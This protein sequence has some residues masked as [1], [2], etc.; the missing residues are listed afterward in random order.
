MISLSEALALYPQSL[1]ALPV[2][3]CA[4]NDALGRV[5]AEPAVSAVDLP[6]FTQSAVDGYALN[7]VEA[8]QTLKLTGDIPAGSSAAHK[9]APG[10]AM[11]ILTGGVLPE[12]ADAVARQ[13]IVERAGPSIR[14]LKPVP[15]GADTRYRGEEL[16]QGEVIALAG[17]R[18]HSGLLAAL[19]MAGVE[20]V[21]A[22]RRPRLALLV[23]GDEIAAMGTA[24]KPGQVY[25]ANGPLMR[26]WFIEHGYPA[27][28]I[29]YVPDRPEAVE[30]ALAEALA[31][32]DFVISTGGVSVGDRDYL[33]DIAPKL[34]VEKIFWKVAQKPGK[35]L[36]FGVKDNKALLA[37]PGNPAAVLIGLAVHAACVLG[38][39]EGVAAP[40]PD[41]RMGIL[42]APVKADAHRDRLLRMS[43]DYDESGRV[44]LSALPKQ[45]SHML[46]NLGR[47]TALGWLEARATPYETGAVVRWLPLRM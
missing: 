26:S 21:R 14:L 19:A 18:L 39:M 27:P 30:Q 11:R 31:C 38:V 44:L 43:L 35:P 40:Q 9:L 10:A 46:S 33:P 22:H 1:R 2:E 41:W 12:G 45:D 6:L 25:D 28:E 23:T 47:A 15:V 4:L 24:L 16:K 7:T 36:W 34:G 13:E 20:E 32:V 5:L 37:M 8:N 29:R 17:Q 3:N 42:E